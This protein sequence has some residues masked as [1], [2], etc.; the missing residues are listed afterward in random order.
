MMER[1]PWVLVPEWVAEVLDHA[2]TS[3]ALAG[4]HLGDTV[5][6]TAMPGQGRSSTFFHLGMDTAMDGDGD[7]EE[8][9]DGLEDGDGGGKKGAATAAPYPFTMS[10]KEP[11]LNP[12]QITCLP[13]KDRMLP[14]LSS[15]RCQCKT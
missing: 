15:L 6:G 3:T 8:V 4:T 2:G 14:L 7:G 5:T 11:H 13:H 9:G 10:S 1:V 12:F